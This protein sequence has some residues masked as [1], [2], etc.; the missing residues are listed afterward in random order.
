MAAIL[1][2]K[3]DAGGLPFSDI[4]YYKDKRLRLDEFKSF[5]KCIDE[6]MGGLFNRH[7][8]HTGEDL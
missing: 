4:W 7:E 3:M 2:A 6:N 5:L 1:N 8:S